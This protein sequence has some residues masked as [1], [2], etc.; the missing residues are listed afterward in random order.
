MRARAMLVFGGAYGNAQATRAL[1]ACD[2]WRRA[3][4]IVCTGDLAA[5]CAD[6]AE[7]CEMIRGLRGKR[8]TIV[9]GNCE[10][11]VGEE[12]D[13]CGCGFAA[14]SACEILS[15]SW[16]RRAKETVAAA[17]KAWMR[18]LP[19]S[20]RIMFGG[21]C[22]AVLHAAPSCDHRFIFASTPAEEKREAIQQTRA[23]GIIAGHSGIPFTQAVSAEDEKHCDHSKHCGGDDE[24]LHGGVWHNSGALGMPANDGTSRV[25]Y[26]FWTAQADGILIEH[27]SLAYDID[28]AA[29]AMQK[30]R[31]PD[32]YRLA[33]TSGIWPS[34][35]VLPPEEKS[36]Q[37][38][39]LT[40]P[41]FL[42][43][44]SKNGG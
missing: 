33:L 12:L 11:S 34:D 14:G 3:D 38:R 2:D 7:V 5:Y 37:S 31:L 8:F 18:E 15:H 10:R 30:A 4:R 28:G 13:D 29:A 36:Q 19:E 6:G 24:I 17:D 41:S 40:L 26:S 43:R 22:L 44:H 20:R 23:D 27:K 1:L 32:G 16:H 21:R 35:S 42:W 9:R 39:P 25:W